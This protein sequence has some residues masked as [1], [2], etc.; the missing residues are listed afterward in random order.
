MRFIF[1]CEKSPSPHKRERKLHGT[2]NLNFKKTTT[3]LCLLVSPVWLIRDLLF[4][5]IILMRAQQT[6]ELGGWVNS[7]QIRENHGHREV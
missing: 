4:R 3:Q 1:C 5:L 7:Q 6:I 2:Q